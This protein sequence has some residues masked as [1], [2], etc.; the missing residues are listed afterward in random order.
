M[1]PPLPLIPFST[2]KTL[3]ALYHS[4]L[5]AS[6]QVPRDCHCP[7]CWDQIGCLHYPLAFYHQRYFFHLHTSPSA[8]FG[9]LPRLAAANQE[10][11]SMVSLLSTHAS[12][13]VTRPPQEVLWPEAV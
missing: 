6:M 11:V 12:S 2:Y 10:P 5:V 13:L 3:L 1:P 8:Q 4:V 9:L 7:S